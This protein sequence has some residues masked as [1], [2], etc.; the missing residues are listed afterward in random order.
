MK[1]FLSEAQ[2]N[3]IA[4]SIFATSGSDHVSS[5]YGFI[6]TIDVVR[7]LGKSGFHPVMALQCKP[8]LKERTEFQKHILRFRHES[9]VTENGIIPEIVMV[10][11]HDGTSSY[12]LRAGIYRLVCANG[13]IVGDEMFCRRV[14]H[15][16]PVI[17]KVVEAA[18]DLIEVVPISVRTVKEW[19]AIPLSIEHKIAFAEAAST[20]KW[21][22]GE[23]PVDP[24]D[25]FRAKRTEDRKNDLWTTFNVIQENMIRGK[26]GYRTEDGR[27]ASTR[28]VNSIHENVRLNTALWTLTEKM[29]TL[30]KATA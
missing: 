19:E 27:R 21:E 2:L 6:P 17:E 24:T 5:R 25:L 12:Q 11:S 26:V 14:K 22:D 1:N 20:L 29:A 8:R 30:L 18:N 28:G 16:G 10:N 15:S 23:C 3:H 9:S 7:G 4:P 13:M